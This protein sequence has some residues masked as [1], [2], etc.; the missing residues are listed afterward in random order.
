[1]SIVNTYNVFISSSQRVSGTSDNFVINMRKPILLT[2]PN[3]YFTCKVGS[4][5]I[6]F[7]FKQLNATNNRNVLNITYSKDAVI[8]A[9]SVIFPVGNYIIT[10]LLAQLQTLILAVHPSLNLNFTYNRSTG[11][12]SFQILGN[13]GV[14]TSI[15]LSFSTNL[16]L[17]SMFGFTSTAEFRYDASN[18]STTATSTQQ[19]LVNPN[20]C[21]YIRSDAL[22]QTG[23]TENL[24]EKDVFSDIICK[25]QIH[26]LPGSWLTYDGANELRVILTNKVIDVISLYLSDS[27]SYS[28][29]LGNLDWSLRLTFEEIQQSGVEDISLNHQPAP[30]KEPLEEK[31]KL[32]DEILEERKKVLADDNTDDLYE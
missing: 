28:L 27:L 12:T 24:V 21:I 1:M 31:Q 6:P 25:L 8:S 10:D 14:Q 9:F 26:N 19:A 16:Y 13:D 29:S 4:A 22:T 5:E 11:F 23:A 7:N 2:R 15:A 3:T 30:P 20:P 17:G 18:V 32:L